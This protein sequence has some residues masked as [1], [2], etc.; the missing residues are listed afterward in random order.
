MKGQGLMRA[1]A[2][3][4]SAL[5]SMRL[6]SVKEGEVGHMSSS[7]SSIIINYHT[8]LN[9]VRNV[10]WVE[11]S[12]QRHSTWRRGFPRGEVNEGLLNQTKTHLKCFLVLLI[13]I[14]LISFFSLSLLS[15]TR[16][17]APTSS[18]SLSEPPTFRVIFISE[19]GHFAH[20][21][22]QFNSIFLW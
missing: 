12:V 11:C 20:C 7:V 1:L 18:A 8:F 19:N 2:L 6:F 5:M 22:V 3:T 4:V 17:R 16:L 9:K 15:W 21:T 14:L 13:F 10:H